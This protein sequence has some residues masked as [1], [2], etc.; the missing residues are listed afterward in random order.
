MPNILRVTSGV[1]SSVGAWIS[2]GA[3]LSRANFL[4]R[5]E[6]MAHA[7]KTV[8]DPR[9]S[10]EKAVRTLEM[11]FEER[12]SLYF[13]YS[14]SLE[15][16][17]LLRDIIIDRSKD[18]DLRQQAMVCLSMYGTDAYMIGL[19]CLNSVLDNRSLE[20]D[21]IVKTAEVVKQEIAEEDSRVRRLRIEENILRKAKHV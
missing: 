19:A 16:L 14:H 8:R 3:I 13:D 21:D 17:F 4:W 6:E 11:L 18:K 20:D 2:K 15:A 12:D 10:S 5:L 1:I 9:C 7:V